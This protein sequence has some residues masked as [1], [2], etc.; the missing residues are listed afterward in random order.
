[1]HTP[2]FMKLK[3]TSPNW[4][5]EN[6]FPNLH[7]LGA[8]F[9]FPPFLERDIRTPRTSS[10]PHPDLSSCVQLCVF[11]QGATDGLLV[12]KNPMAF[13]ALVTSR[14][15]GEMRKKWPTR[16]FKPC[17]FHPRSLEVTYITPWKGHVFTIPKKGHIESPRK[18]FFPQVLQT[19]SCFS[20]GYGKS[21]QTWKFYGPNYILGDP[22]TVSFQ[23]VQH[24]WICIC[25]NHL[26][27]R[28]N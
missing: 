28:V 8:M 16:W 6:H 26:T 12:R 11:G 17:P 2:E 5:P 7:F 25:N 9:I 4:N 14:I 3:T 27:L 10:S 21:Q 13:K 24:A 19:F 23:G 15:N 1:M 20:L 22:P 18:H